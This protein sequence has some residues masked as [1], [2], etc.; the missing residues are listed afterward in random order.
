MLRCLRRRPV[1]SGSTGASSGNGLLSSEGA[2]D[3][4]GLAVGSLAPGEAVAEGEDATEGDDAEDG[5]EDEDED[6]VGAGSA[7]VVPGAEG[8]RHGRAHCHGSDRHS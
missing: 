1:S 6:A 3:V 2:G 5:D 8:E 7:E 4:D